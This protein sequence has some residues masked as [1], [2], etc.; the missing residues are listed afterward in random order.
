MTFANALGGPEP[1]IDPHAHFH[2][3][4]TNRADWARY[5]ASRLEQGERLGIR[6]HVASIL[7]SWG[8]TSPTYFA[9]PEDQTRAN[10]F[11]LAL[12][13]QEAPRVKAFVAVNPN[14]TA[15]ALHEI[16]QMQGVFFLSRLSRLKRD[17][18]LKKWKK[19]AG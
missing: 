4:Y 11:M 9:S 2:T 18:A 6:C 5:N 8:H 16:E 17:M 1:L 15:H 14:F 10:D 3:P 7:G 12:A 13:D 19:R